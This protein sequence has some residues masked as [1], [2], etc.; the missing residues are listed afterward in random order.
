MIRLN[1]LTGDRPTG[2]MHVGHYF[3]SLKNRFAMQKDYRCFFMIA[4][5]QAL[6]THADRTPEIEG[7]VREMALDYLAAGFDPEQGVCFLQS[8]VPQL[9]E[10]TTIFS[11]LVT[12]SRLLRNPTIK[13]EM[14]EMGLSA[15]ATYGF[16]GYPV[17]Q[18]ADILLF[19]PALV[20]VGPDQQ[21]H[22]E[23]AQEVAARF[24]RLYGTLFPI[25]EAMVGERLMGTDGRRKMGKSARNA[26]HLSDAPEIVA[27]KVGEMV[28]D[29]AR[30]RRS[31]P[32]HPEVCPVFNV[33]RA[34]DPD[35]ENTV[36]VPCRRAE[37]GCADCK[38]GLGARLNVFLEP[39][40][41]R[42]S[43]CEGRPG[44]IRDILNMGGAE[45]RVEGQRTLEEVKER[46]GLSYKGLLT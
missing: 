33:H 32:G 36:A 42:R 1:V 35:A 5:Y 37:I 19:R 44:L 20:P 24:N 27:E 39:F 25:P 31:D 10:L 45:A 22:V 46:M 6:T 26:I 40:R 16:V 38:A 34:L 11:N 29:P 28:T 30:A 3:G 18:A 43:R 4:D 17:S 2:R 15:R 41:E 13:E 14:H 7:N 23:L 9:A 12:L 8:Q 21:P